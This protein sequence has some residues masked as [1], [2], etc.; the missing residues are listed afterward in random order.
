MVDELAVVFTATVDC[1]RGIYRGIWVPS[2]GC[3][4]QVYSGVWIPSFDSGRG[5]CRC[6]WQSNVNIGS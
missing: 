5:G 4:T 6:A 3:G 2:L 1:G